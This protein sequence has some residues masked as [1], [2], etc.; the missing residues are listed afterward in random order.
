MAFS[1]VNAAGISVSIVY[2][3]H[4]P[5]LY[6]NNAHYKAGWAI[7]WVSGAWMLMTLLD[8]FTRSASVTMEESPEINS[9][10]NVA[11]YTRFHDACCID[12]Y[13]WSGDSHRRTDSVENKLCNSSRS[14]SLNS[15]SARIHLS[16]TVNHKSD[17]EEEDEKQYDD[18]EKRLFFPESFTVNSRVERHDPCDNPIRLI[19]VL[20]ILCSVL[21]YSI[22][23]LGFVG[24]TSGIVVYSGIFRGARIFDGM[25]HFVK[26]AIFLWYGFLALGRWT[27]TFV[28]L[29]WAWN[30]KPGAEIVGSKEARVPS[31]EFVESFLI[32]FYGASHMFFEH[33]GAWGKA[34]HAQDFEHIAIT[35]MFFGGGLVG[36]Q[37]ISYTVSPLTISQ[38]GMLIESYRIRR[39]FNTNL[40]VPVDKASNVK[41]RT[42]DFSAHSLNPIPALVIMLL[43]ITMSHH[44]QHSALAS[45]VHKQCG[46]LFVGAALARGVTYTTLWLR[47]PQSYL[48]SRPPSELITAF[49]LVSGGGLFMASN[50]DTMQAIVSW[51]LDEMFVF[52]VAMGLTALFM[53]LVGVV[54]AVGAWASRRARIELCKS[55]ESLTEG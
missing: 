29:G 37:S 25:A 18:G 46:T 10:E 48:P 24:L 17:G 51:G 27:G 30:L 34:W 5:D 21:D 4:T 41:W 52:T 15:G 23:I 13:R 28:D 31:A 9:Q 11:E 22:L 45:A 39:I 20:N 49:C 38:L 40:T 44:T 14:S 54:L 6:E 12:A 2:S 35:V 32:F 8:S 26:G 16:T 55:C 33:L 7:T 3:G 36:C 42:T 19:T 1:I 47:A 50:M 43:G 53:A